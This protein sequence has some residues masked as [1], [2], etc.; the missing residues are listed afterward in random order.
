MIQR[1]DEEK[2]KNM[3]LVEVRRL[4]VRWKSSVFTPA[5]ATPVD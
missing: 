3:L 5:R 1:V 4:P 2:N